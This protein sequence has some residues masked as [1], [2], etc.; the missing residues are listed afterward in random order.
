M[1]KQWQKIFSTGLSI[2]AIL[3]GIYLAVSLFQ[4][5]NTWN[6]IFGWALLIFS[7]GLL[8]VDGFGS[9][10]WKGR[11][12]IGLAIAGIITAAYLIPTWIANNNIANSWLG[13]ILIALGAIVLIKDGFN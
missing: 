9:S 6:T 8:I 11:I 3:S 4:N 12:N 10:D 1:S 7:A 13:G 5:N 2:S